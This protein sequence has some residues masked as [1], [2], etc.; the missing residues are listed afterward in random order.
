MGFHD[1]ETIVTLSNAGEIKIPM[2]PDN[3]SNEEILMGLIITDLNSF[4]PSL[5]EGGEIDTT[6]IEATAER[7]GIPSNEVHKSKVYP[8]P[9][10]SNNTLTVEMYQQER[11]TYI[12]QLLTINGQVIL[13]KEFWMDKTSRVTKIP[14]PTLV[15]GV[16]FLR[17]R[18]KLSGKSYTE[19]IIIE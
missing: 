4:P 5:M 10:K 7:K 1:T 13:S 17:S 2:I 18:N 8:N 14:I 3:S 16:Y 12:F 19:K 15:P 11:G 6:T 9:L